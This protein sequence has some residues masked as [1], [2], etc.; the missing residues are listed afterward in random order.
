MAD[1]P[2]I[3]GL[4]EDLARD[5]VSLTECLRKARLAAARLKLDNIAEWIDLELKGY[6]ATA[7]LPAYR[8]KEGL[9]LAYNPYHGWQ[10]IQS[11]DREFLEKISKAPIG[12]PIGVIENDA[13]RK[14]GHLE[15]GLPA[16]VRSAISQS[17]N[18]P[19]SVRLWLSPNTPLEIVEAVRNLLTDWC[20][21][22][23]RSGIIG[24]GLA[25]GEADQRAAPSA[26][27]RFV[28]HNY[29]SIGNI[30]GHAEQSTV[31]GSSFAPEQLT[32]LRRL[33][34]QIS[35]SAPLLPEGI[36]SELEGVNTQLST[37]LKAPQPDGSRVKELVSSLRKI[38]ESA[39]GN[40]AAQGILTLLRAI[41]GT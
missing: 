31:V 39:T 35:Q 26:T 37:E 7:N 3:S 22:L 19:A 23:E 36:R 20:L 17:L 40:L 5:D 33:T 8:L 24:E 2:F 10:P 14:P 1:K 27:D 9:P 38:A 18:F 13:R 6:G 28:V 21:E 41:V 29:G 32:S 15:F 25:F 4:L 34:A 16:A 12:S 30:V 11:A